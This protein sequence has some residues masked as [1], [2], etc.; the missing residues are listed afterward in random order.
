[1]VQASPDFKRDLYYRMLLLRKAEE[2]II[3]NYAQREMR[4][5]PHM[6]I[7][8]EAVAVGVCA[9]LRKDDVIFPYY[10]SHGWYLAKGGDLKAMM[11]ELHGRETGCSHGWGGSMHL[12][13][14]AAG[15]MGTSA[16]VAGTISH[17]AGAALAFK[18]R[19]QDRVAVVSF[20][21]G[22][23]EE[24]VFHETLNF[25]SLRK[26]PVIFIC[27]NNQY[28][29]NTHI[30]D[31]QAQPEIY[32]HAISHGMTGVRIDGNNVLGVYEETQKAVD[33]ARRGEGPTLIEA[34]TYR[35]F[36][37]CGVFTDYDLGYRTEE[38]AKEWQA[39][40]PLEQAKDFVTEAEV[41]QMS[42]DIEAQISEAFDYARSSPFPSVLFAQ[43][44]AQ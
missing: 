21:D 28:A 4:S 6:Y 40:G 39:K 19:Q 3:A 36:E 8:H 32:R 14:I 38:E 16:I 25:A 31:R 7:G 44:V 34:M 11:A 2:S 29:T 17:A 23:T 42:A 37:H 41:A 1:M 22:A 13:D 30:R 12:I 15:V 33:R 18:I 9:A 24:G 10:R 26:L 43:G 20:G 27:E 35:I 5:P